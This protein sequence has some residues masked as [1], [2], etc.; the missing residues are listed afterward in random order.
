M[1]DVEGML[2]TRVAALDRELAALRTREGRVGGWSPDAPPATAG[3]IDDEFNDGSLG[4]AWTEYD[5]DSKTAWTVGNGGLRAVVSTTA[6]NNVNGIHQAIPT[7]DFSI[8]AKIHLAAKELATF[9]A[10]IA[11]FEDPSGNNDIGTWA[12]FR[13]ATAGYPVRA[14]S[15]THINHTAGAVD[16]IAPATIGFGFEKIYLRL[17][18]TGT[19]YYCDFSFG[20]VSWRTMNSW[21]AITWG[22]T[23]TKVGLYVNNNNTG[24]AQTAY[25]QFFRYVASDVGP[26]GVMEGNRS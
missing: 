22:F 9:S 11:V 3:S 4:A 7:G 8:A 19:N 14:Y 1:T 6:G 17:R 10:G 12:V 26:T 2:A 24:E 20:G 13:D 5:P 25:F 18:R 15:A 16:K 23:P 21:A